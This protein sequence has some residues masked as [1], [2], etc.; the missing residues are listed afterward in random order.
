MNFVIAAI[1]KIVAPRPDR[2]V[3]LT[4]KQYQ[5]SD[6]DF[7]LRILINT[8]FQH[9]I[10]I[11]KQGHKTNDAPRYTTGKLIRFCTSSAEQTTS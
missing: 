4:H 3:Q 2:V 6:S 1:R 5:I 10:I 11:Y 9:W 7:M 8:Q